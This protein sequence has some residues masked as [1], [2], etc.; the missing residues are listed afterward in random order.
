MGGREYKLVLIWMGQERKNL[1]LQRWQREALWWNMNPAAAWQSW[2][3]QRRS[4]SKQG[5][6]SR[7]EIGGLERAGCADRSQERLQGGGSKAHP[8]Q[9]SSELPTWFHT[10]PSHGCTNSCALHNLP[11]FPAAH[12]Q[13]KQPGPPFASSAE[14][15]NQ[16]K[17]SHFL[18]KS[19]PFSRSGLHQKEKLTP[20]PPPS[21][22][23]KK[24]HQITL[25]LHEN[26][27]HP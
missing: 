13:K 6:M 20:D 11:N 16:K 3:P 2:M 22:C 10:E 12:C 4:S 9:R 25:W 18:A 14:K 17:G 1:V 19:P 24:T 27:I 8:A 26:Q 5:Q 21:P 23:K 15:N 7:G